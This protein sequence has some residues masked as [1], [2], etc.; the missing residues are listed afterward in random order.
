MKKIKLFSIIGLVLCL[1]YPTVVR[2]KTDRGN[3]LDEEG[4]LIVWEKKS[5]LW[6]L[7]SYYSVYERF[8]NDDGSPLNFEKEI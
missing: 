3:Y 5:F 8:C 4:C 1:L 2:A 6:G 7:I